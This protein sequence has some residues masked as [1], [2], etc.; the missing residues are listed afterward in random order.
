MAKGRRYIRTIDKQYSDKEAIGYC[1][2][3]LHRGYITV[4]NYKSHK[5]G[6]KQCNYFQ[7]YTDSDY[8][9]SKKIALFRKK[10]VK[11]ICKLYKNNE[12]SKDYKDY[13][14]NKIRDDKLT[15]ITDEERALLDFD[16]IYSNID[17]KSVI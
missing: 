5:C 11:K 14:I 9:R 7:R 8:Y 1:H 13:L 10:L 4:K 6:E 17:I 3:S 15:K 2:C 16:T 12:I